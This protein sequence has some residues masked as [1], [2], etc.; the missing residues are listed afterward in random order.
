MYYQ[1]RRLIRC[2]KREQERRERED[3]EMY[4]SRN[5]A[6]IFFKNVKHL[7][8]GCKPGASS[9][10]NERINLVT[11]TQ[12]VLWLWRHHFSTLFRFEGDI[13]LKSA[14]M[15]LTVNKGKT[16]YILMRSGSC[17][18]SGLRS[19]L[20]GIISMLSRSLYTLASPLTQTTTSAG[21]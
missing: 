6:Q 12:G 9:C 5:V 2:K 3:I 1:E 10:R 13:K 15:G 11:D 19:G 8:E 21:K 14:K 4:R 20:T 18:V 16:K 17:I 7:T